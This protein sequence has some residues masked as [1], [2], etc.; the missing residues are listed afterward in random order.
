MSL[1]TYAPFEV[2]IH[3]W[4]HP[5]TY[6]NSS[7]VNINNKWKSFFWKNVISN[8]SFY[9][10]WS[11]YNRYLHRNYQKKYNEKLRFIIY[12]LNICIMNINQNGKVLLDNCETSIS[13]CGNKNTEN[14]VLLF[15]FSTTMIY[16][17]LVGL[18]NFNLVL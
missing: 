16:W 18:K 10:F 1:E 6:E 3:T 12:M 9:Y 5:S 4:K 13:N 11:F 7:K 2:K 17:L 14:C 8:S 15:T